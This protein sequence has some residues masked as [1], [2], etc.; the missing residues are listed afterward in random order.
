MI[1]VFAGETGGN[2]LVPVDSTIPAVSGYAVFI[3]R[4]KLQ[5]RLDGILQSGMLVIPK[6]HV[7]KFTPG[8]YLMYAQVV[9]N[10]NL[11]Y[12][13]VPEDVEIVYIPDFF[14]NGE[15]ISTDSLVNNFNQHLTDYNNPHQ[16]TA[17]QVGAEPDLGLPAADGYILSSTTTGVRT[18]IPDTGGGGGGGG[19][20]T[21]HHTQSNAASVW[22]ITHNLGKKPSVEIIDSA[23]DNW[24]GIVTYVNNNQLT[25]TFSSAFSGNAYLN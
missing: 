15:F 6:F 5:Y 2:I 11:V 18:W 3:G 20:L 19:D 7:S 9:D 4:N 1:Q 10:T 17:Q 22:T 24:F 25:I 21:Y 16:T 14:V 13:L 8:D 12:F 23:G